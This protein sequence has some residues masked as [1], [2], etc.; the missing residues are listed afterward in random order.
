MGFDKS[1]GINGPTK[2]VLTDGDDNQKDD[3]QD[4][5]SGSLVTESAM[6]G[7]ASDLWIDQVGKESN[8]RDYGE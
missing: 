5:N 4:D 2:E 1:S 6:T 8:G 3:D 7:A